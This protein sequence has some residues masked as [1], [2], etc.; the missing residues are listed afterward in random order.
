M[1]AL[2]LGAIAIVERA[3]VCLGVTTGER[4]GRGNRGCLSG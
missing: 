4:K 3:A 1:S 2:W